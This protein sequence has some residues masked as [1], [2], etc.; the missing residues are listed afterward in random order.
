MV[1]D[2]KTSLALNWVR[3]VAC[4]LILSC[5]YVGMMPRIA[6]VSQIFNVGNT[7]FFLLSGFLNAS[8]NNTQDS[9]SWLGRRFRKI[10]IPYY[11]YCFTIIVLYSEKV[12]TINVISGV[13][14]IQAFLQSYLPYSGHLWY[15]SI[16]CL[17]YVF[18]PA[19]SVAEQNNRRV[20]AVIASVLSISFVLAITGP[21]HGIRV[22][23]NYLRDVLVYFIGM[24]ARRRNWISKGRNNYFLLTILMTI[25]QILRL[26]IIILTRIIPS[27]TL[28][29]I[30]TYYYCGFSHFILAA[31]ISITIIRFVTEHYDFVRNISSP[32]I[33]ISS[34]SYEIYLVH[35]V[36]LL[37]E[38]SMVGLTNIIV[39][40]ILIFFGITV[41]MALVLHGISKLFQE[42][43]LPKK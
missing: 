39:I 40:N 9:F 41:A 14:N 11:L 10:L 13:L 17:C 22:L 37:G 30:Y 32:V 7:I 3:T 12:S 26:G 25:A 18:T 27:A 31:W 21:T 29:N 15:L 28:N 1:I 6:F 38:K 34:I 24:M 35:N 36:L 43:L 8:I 33:F 19:L 20:I 23:S 2:K 5:H 42:L 4:L 16:I